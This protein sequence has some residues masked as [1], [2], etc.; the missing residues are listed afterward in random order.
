MHVAFAL[1]G[2]MD[3]TGM[4]ARGGD[5]VDHSYAMTTARQTEN[6]RWS[7]DLFERGMGARSGVLFACLLADECGN[8]ATLSTNV[9]RTGSVQRSCVQ[10]ACQL[11][12]DWD[13]G[14]CI[15][16]VHVAKASSFSSVLCVFKIH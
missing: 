5:M 10:L 4:P 7:I 16:A 1:V 8:K 15:L 6:R 12:P 14:W 13:S 2:W 3:A 11:C 9:C